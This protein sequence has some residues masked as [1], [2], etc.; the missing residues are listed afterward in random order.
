MTK[1][2]RNSRDRVP[3]D[4]RSL[5]AQTLAT[6][7]HR[8]D[9]LLLGCWGCSSRGSTWGTTRG[10]TRG[11]TSTTSTTRTGTRA[12]RARTVV[13]A[14]TV[15]AWGRSTVATSLLGSDTNNTVMDGSLN[16]VVLL[17]VHLGEHVIIVAGSI[18]DV[19]HRRCFDDIPNHKPL[20]RFVL[21]NVLARQH[22]H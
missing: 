21:G 13:L 17:V 9:A 5:G 11:T 18:A 6:E 4:E 20:Y 19:T 1:W 16:R 3:D 15:E 22:A 8:G 12:T 7:S 2:E 10:T 14:R